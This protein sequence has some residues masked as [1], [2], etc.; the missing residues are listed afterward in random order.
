MP[1]GI[2]VRKIKYLNNIIEQK[3]RFIKRRLST[4]L[5][6]QSF[7]TAKAIISGEEVMHMMKKKQVYQKVQSF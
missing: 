6:L 5:D 4:M 3:H 7:R 2:Q 1:Q